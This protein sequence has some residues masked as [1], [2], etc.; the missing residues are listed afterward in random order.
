VAKLSCR[1]S[2]G[3]RPSEATITVNE[4]DGTPQ[5]FPLDRGMVSRAGSRDAIPVR[6]IQKDETEQFA[7]I[8]LPVEADSGSQRIWVKIEDLDPQLEHVG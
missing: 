5:H 4:Y 1:V 3:L 6:V 7:L 2:D 8:S